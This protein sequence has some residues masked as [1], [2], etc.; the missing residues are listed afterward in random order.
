MTRHILS[1]IIAL[2]MFLF[3]LTGGLSAEI[4][5]DKDFGFSL[6]IPEGFEMTDSTE[7][8]MSIL[9]T[10]QNIPVTLAIKIYYKS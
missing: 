8:G 5:Y 2:L 6:D 3:C 1:R 10:H 4:I 7:D 9:L